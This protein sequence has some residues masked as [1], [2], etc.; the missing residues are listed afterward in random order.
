MSARK[1]AERAVLTSR[2]ASVSS[3]SSTKTSARKS[4]SPIEA[5][6]RSGA[7]PSISMPKWRPAALGEPLEKKAVSFERIAAS[8]RGEH[9]GLITV[10]V[11]VQMDARRQRDRPQFPHVAP[12]P[13]Q[14]KHR[15][16]A[17]RIGLDPSV[18]LGQ[19]GFDE[20]FEIERFVGD[21]ERPQ[22]GLRAELL[23]AQLESLEY[24]HAAL[25]DDR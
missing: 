15:P 8:H 11:A 3:S 2:E 5:R 18:L 14:A 22:I 12:F 16:R 10:R 20:V 23:G 21:A 9:A 7:G 13:F 17:E 24:A 6:T 1:S 4:R 19:R 25:T